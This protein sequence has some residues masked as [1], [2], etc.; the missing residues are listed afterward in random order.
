[1]STSWIKKNDKEIN[2]IDENNIVGVLRKQIK[3]VPRV[4][5]P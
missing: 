2:I 4:E 1:M 5:Y 3:H